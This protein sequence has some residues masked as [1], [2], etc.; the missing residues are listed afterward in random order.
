VKITFSV[1]ARRDLAK[2]TAYLLD[3]NTDAATAF[4][5]AIDAA[6]AYLVAHPRA[7]RLVSLKGRHAAARRWNVPPMAIFYEPRGDALYVIRIRHGAR[8]PIT[9]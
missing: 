6:L 9:R 7:G 1:P 5:D 2:R 3:R 8:R 4:R